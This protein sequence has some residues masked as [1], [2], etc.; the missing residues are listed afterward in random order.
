M[1]SSTSLR[2]P[3]WLTDTLGL[4]SQ[5][6]RRVGRGEI[7]T[8]K[9]PSPSTYPEMYEGRSISSCREPAYC[10]VHRF[11]TSE[12]YES[13][14]TASGASPRRDQS[15]QGHTAEAAEDFPRHY[16]PTNLLVGEGFAVMSGCAHG[17]ASMQGSFIYPTRN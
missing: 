12:S 13:G 8:V 10:A 14:V 17:V 15:L 11:A 1:C 3:F 2:S 4:T 7:E 16:P 6:T 9:H 5:P